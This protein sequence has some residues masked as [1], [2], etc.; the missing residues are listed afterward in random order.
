MKKKTKNKIIIIII[1]ILS[2]FVIYFTGTYDKLKAKTINYFENTFN[3]SNLKLIQGTGNLIDKASLSTLEDSKITGSNYSFNTIDNA[4]FRVLE[5]DEKELY[6][7]IYANIEAVEKYFRPVVNLKKDHIGDVVEA[8]FNDHPELFWVDTNFSYKYIEKGEVVQIIL[9]YNST[10][11]NIEKSKETFNQAIEKIVGDAN[12]Y[13]SIYDK[14]KFVHDTLI[15]NNKYD[16]NE[17][18]NQ[19][20]YSALVKGKTVCAGYSRAF[21]IIMNKLGIRT[22]FI[23]GDS[24]G[25]HS[26]NIIELEDEYY[27]VDLTWDNQKNI[28]Y[29]YFNVPDSVFSK[30]HIRKGL[31][32]Y[33]P[34]CR[35][36][37]YY[38]YESKLKPK[39]TKPS[40]EEEN[41][42]Q[43]KE[44]IE[45]IEE[46]PEE[47]YE[48]YENPEIIDKR[49]EYEN[50][51]I[52]D[53]RYEYEYEEEY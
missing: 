16:K 46:E 38:N 51:E 8:V 44:N 3:K 13:S 34:V 15:T 18:L 20:A 1:F 45:T 5:D 14:E 10:S 12:T 6:K 27:N 28:T 2:A 24:N 48:I 33:L 36:E 19:S 49:Y 53:K 42:F 37:K 41:E 9:N 32:I 31:S 25:D 17:K 23:S 39:E 52:I 43:H 50:P 47:Y 7:Q 21:Q 29:R 11:K 26:W 30:T 4:Y 35:G 22:Y 40:I